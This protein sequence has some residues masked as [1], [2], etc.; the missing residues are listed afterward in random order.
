MHKRTWSNIA[1]AGAVSLALA[2]CGGAADEAANVPEVAEDGDLCGRC[3]SVV[4]A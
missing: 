2:A 4:G 3:D 1:L